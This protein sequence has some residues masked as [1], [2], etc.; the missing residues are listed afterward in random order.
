[1]SAPAVWGGEYAAGS[2]MGG[3]GR[4]QG[5]A[6]RPLRVAHFTNSFARGGAEEHILGLLRALDPAR[7]RQWLVCPPE[8]AER[9]EADL[10]ATVA[11]Y[12]IRL[13]RLRDWRAG[14]R[15]AGW[16]RQEQI[17]VVHSHLFYSSLFGT[18]MARLAGVATVV[19]T[20]HL[21]EQWRRG[22][23][24]HYE[25]DR[26]IGW[27]VDAYIAVSAAN[28]AYLRQIKGLPERK[29][30]IIPNGINLEA[31]APSAAGARQ[32]AIYRAWLAVPPGDP[33]LLVSGRLEAQKGH[34]V[35][36]R[37]MPALRQIFPRL[38]AVFTGEGSQREALMAQTAA[39]G[40]SEAVHFAGFQREMAAWL[41]A[42]DVVV[43]PS[44]FEGLPLAA[45]E[46]L[47]AARPV[48]ATAVDGTV[49][50][51]RHEQTGLLVPAGDAAALGAAV[52][53]LLTEPELARRLA[54]SGFEWAQQFDLRR[55]ASATGELYRALCRRSRHRQEERP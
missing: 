18:P 11:T 35:L 34:A 3:H 43:L 44:W 10:P 55:Q 30:H 25:V 31:F 5:R 53:R 49:E 28:A 4:Q 1:M 29:L 7:F 14:L 32:A 46:A 13:R 12:P 51:V 17:D 19:E 38:K 33:L 45:V 16:L 6:A 22:L 20:P 21:R 54:T 37:A 48:V 39:A 50:V 52:A 27:G 36:L 23:K 15:W 24:A 2:F 40:L 9:M 41:L 26:L 8:L 42:A 47:A